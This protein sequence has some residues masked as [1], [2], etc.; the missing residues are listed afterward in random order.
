MGS[1]PAKIWNAFGFT[2]SR[3]AKNM[4]KV[5]TL[6]KVE[7]WNIIRLCI[8][9]KRK[10]FKDFTDITTNQNTSHSTGNKRVKRQKSVDSLDDRVVKIWKGF[11]LPW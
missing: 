4:K 5:C 9:L 3:P 2:E 8:L 1:K 10:Q 7:L 11:V 6:L